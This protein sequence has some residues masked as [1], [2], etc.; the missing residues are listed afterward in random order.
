MSLIEERVFTSCH[1]YKLASKQ[2]EIIIYKIA[3]MQWKKYAVV[4]CAGSHR[5]NKKISLETNNVRNMWEFYNCGY[6]DKNLNEKKCGA[7]LSDS[8]HITLALI[9]LD[10][11]NHFISKIKK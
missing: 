10:K 7:D 3:P 5:E 8:Y 1:I 2:H 6:A 4:Y 9:L 11:D